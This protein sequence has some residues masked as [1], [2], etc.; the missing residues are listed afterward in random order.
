[1]NYEELWLSIAFLAFVAVAYKPLKKSI[2]SII[3]NR[4]NKI[5]QDLEE[6]EKLRLEA[7]QSLIKM[8]EEYS[9]TQELC[10]IIYQEAEIKA[11]NIIDDA[12]KKAV[13]LLDKYLSIAQE[14]ITQQEKSITEHIKRQILHNALKVVQKVL[15]EYNTNSKFNSK[16]ITRDIALLKK[17]MH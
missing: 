2:L 1:M 4:I 6:A 9:K 12:N 10:N 7:Q 17:F 8:K 5:Q 14:N 13:I 15:E 16:L 3:D 11:Q